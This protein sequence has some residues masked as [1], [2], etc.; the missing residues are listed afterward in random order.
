[1]STAVVEL[2][3]P[4]ELGKKTQKA[5]TAFS[6]IKALE[7][8]ADRALADA[9]IKDGKQLRKDIE[10]VR[11]SF[12]KPLDEKKKQV[13][14]LE[15][16]LAA[17]LDSEV[18]RLVGLV[19]G[20]LKE[21]H[22]KAEAE[23]QRILQEEEDRLKRLRS[24][25]SIAKVQAQTEEALAQVVAPTSGVRMQKMHELTDINLVPRELLMLDPAKVKKALGEGQRNIPGLRIWEEPIRS[26]R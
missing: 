7:S 1:M 21:Q 17:G 19:N 10:E 20:Y 23:K 3:F 8:D 9:L 24:P 12:T 6:K 18:S 25:V 4:T 16:D 11:M 2:I 13:M 5:V 14:Q 15:K 22:R 26:G